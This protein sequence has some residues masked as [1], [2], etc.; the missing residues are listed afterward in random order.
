M[1][2]LFLVHGWGGNAAVWSPVVGSLADRFRV[3]PLDLPGCGG[4]REEAV[5]DFDAV[6][7]GLGARF[8]PGAV[9]LAWSMGGL[10]AMRAVRSAPAPVSA[11][12]LVGSFAR[13]PECE[14]WPGVKADQFAEM[15]AGLGSQAA[16]VLRRFRG[17]CLAPEGNRE[18]LRCLEDDIAGGGGVS[19]AALRNGLRWLRETD[20]R[21]SMAGL[22]TPVTLIHGAQDRVA[23]AA[24]APRMRQLLPDARLKTL[25]GAG[26]APFRTRPREFLEMLDDVA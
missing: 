5:G 13:L 3:H 12:W 22:T 23:P 20:L 17:L 8:T 14:N 7:D 10:L 11:L 2:D 24:L 26:H 25:P 9:V 16:L 6:A 18:G 15:E 21:D 1:R 19:D 4:R